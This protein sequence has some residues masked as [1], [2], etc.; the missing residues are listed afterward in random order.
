MEQLRRQVETPAQSGARSSKETC[1]ARANNCSE[2]RTWIQ[3]GIV[4]AQDNSESDKK[5]HLPTVLG[6]FETH[7]KGSIQR[8][9]AEKWVE[10][11]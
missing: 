5:Y 3:R 10:K 4:E 6:S 9:T 8:A 7:Q 2:L 1:L 11:P